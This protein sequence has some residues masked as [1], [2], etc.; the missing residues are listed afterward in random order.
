MLKIVLGLVAVLAIIGAGTAV[1]LTGSESPEMDDTSTNKPPLTM[2]Q[3][4][5]MLL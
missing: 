5:D 4:I 1:C 2:S 3:K